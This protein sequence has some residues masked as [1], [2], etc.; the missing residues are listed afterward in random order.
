MAR[1]TQAEKARRLN[2]ARALL[3]DRPHLPDAARHLADQLAISTRQAYRYLSQARRLTAPVP[4]L[5]GKD[6]LS[7]RLPRS[8]IRRLRAYSAATGTAVSELVA[9]ALQALLASR[10]RRG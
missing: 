10:A 7:V 3:Q 1:V 5:D 8:L 2:L 4:V 9:R 6:V